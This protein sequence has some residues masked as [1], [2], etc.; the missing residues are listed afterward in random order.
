MIL[1]C[2]VCQPPP[3]HPLM[4]PRVEMP[5][6]VENEVTALLLSLG[7]VVTGYGLSYIAER[8]TPYLKTMKS[9]K[10]RLYCSQ[11]M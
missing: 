8:D 1:S 7:S 5:S 2:D 10:K 6:P 9:L 4:P 3:A 11:L